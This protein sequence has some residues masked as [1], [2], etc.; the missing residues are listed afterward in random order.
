[1]S[2]THRLV[3]ARPSVWP[4]VAVGVLV[5]AA[6]VLHRELAAY[7]FHE[8]MQAARAVPPARLAR[9]L[10]CTA[11]AYAVLPGYDAMALRYIGFHLPLRRTAFASF[12]AYAF[13]QML[14]FPLLTGGS[15]RYRLWSAWGLSTAQIA[16]A[17]GFVAFSFALGMLTV[18]GLAFV[19]EPASTAEVLG[20][21]AS[22]LRGLGLLSLGLVVAYAWWCL[23]RR[24]S[25]RLGPLRVPAP[26][27]GLL[28]AQLVVPTLD[29]TLAG[30]ALYVLL[31][32]G[33][34]LTLVAFLGIFLLAQFAGLV[35][36]VP[37]GLGVVETILILLLRP[38]APVTELVGSLIAYRAVYY[39]LP[40]CV[41]VLLLAQYELRSYAPQALGAARS[42]GSWVP[43]LVPQVLSGA[44]FL[45]GVILLGSGATPAIPGRLAWLG[46]LLPLGVIEASHFL[47]SVAGVCLL[48]LAWALWHRLDAAYGL[49]VLLLIV[50]I[51]A[52]LLK[53]GD[54]EEATVLGIV[55]AAVLPAR[56]YFYRKAALAAEPLET[57]WLLAILAV[58]GGFIWLG[59]FAH[60]HAEY[61]NELW[62]RF[63][64]HADAPRFLRA[65]VGVV[66]VLI[67]AG[68]FR[69][70]RG[71]PAA[72]PLPD[73][74]ELDR[75]A[76]LI[77]ELP[78]VSA[79][80]ALVGDKALLFSGTGRGL[81]MYGV[82]GR[83][84]VALGDPVGPAAEQVE[85]VW[86][87]RELADRHGGWTVFYEVGVGCLPLYIDLGLTLLKLGEE[88]RVPLVD[89]TL[90]VP[91]R[92]SL[93]RSQRQMQR[94][95]VCFEVVPAADIPPLLP[96][97]REISDAWL[98]EKRTREKGFSLGF[99]DEAYIARFP[100]A[101][102][103]RNGEI[104]AFANVWTSRPRVKLSMDLMRYRPD[105]P[106]GV[107]QY[108]CT[109][110]MLWGRAEGY[111][112]FGLGMAPFSG[113]ERRALAP[114]WS[115]LGAFMYR[116][117]E[118]FYNFQGL[119]EF[120]EKFD[121]VWEPRYLASPG[122]LALPRVLANVAALIGGGLRGVV[123][124]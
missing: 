50:G 82:E 106:P 110:L 55:L 59:L 26:S 81:L 90:D 66:G 40:F 62:W 115:R 95:G 37:G 85:L 56:R 74:A 72:V 57:G 49:T 92:R 8:L 77:A 20:L 104:I 1:M 15:V 96:V 22:A 93:R 41:G 14:G 48:V 31:P 32:G 28:G 42:V 80:L 19:L 46:R 47:G 78:D 119:R 99:F 4:F 35:S 13:S 70:F 124:K 44:V 3:P 111:Q 91:N 51:G 117:G 98:L 24:H 76:E 9:A 10:A 86:R 112:Y 122:G 11:L 114:L 97:L 54:W 45:T 67:A 109:E 33:H 12:I 5:L 29:W 100:V 18:G 30:A 2:G 21:S 83:S 6:A 38:Y 87:F 17:V 69:L 75:A 84:W 116:Y 39:L 65:S 58:V 34:G 118:H 23:R 88:A 105:A 36:H 108:L 25:I 52:S 27:P 16:R 123:T 63:A 103:R 43:R 102:A 79:S 61:R 53:G 89:F 7:R 73:K 101:L 121:P 107:M 68:L 113:M 64:L 94:E 71:A 120:K 60:R